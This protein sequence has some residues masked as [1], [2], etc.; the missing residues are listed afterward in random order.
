[1]KYTLRQLEVFKDLTETGS[2]SR[3]AERLHLTQPAVSIQLKRFQDQFDVPLYEIVGRRV[4]VTPF[5]R[6]L[7]LKATEILE[8]VD[9]LGQMSQS[10][11]G[12]LTGKL[13]FASVST[14][15][16]VLPYFIAP[17]FNEN[18][19]IDLSIDITNKAQVMES[20]RANTVDFALVSVLPTDMS[21]GRIGLLENRLELVGPSDGLYH[22]KEHDVGLLSTI[23]LIFREAGSG[24]RQTME[25]YFVQN[26]IIV[27]KT[28]E[29]T[30]NEAV[31]QAVLAGLG[32]SVMPLIG[33]RNEIN[34]GQI[35]VIRLKGF[36]VCTEWNII[37]RSEKRLSPAAESFLTY[38]SAKKQAVKDAQFSW[39]KKA[40]L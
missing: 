5:G 16:Y 12:V 18:P 33:L 20:L 38:L 15:K 1:M 14:G 13:S 36:P 29:L 9:A 40:E 7:A 37:W 6:L 21:V 11:K 32:Y 39:L 34:E 17:F 35:E 31:K 25:R 28:M 3:T 24:T 22:G 30:S 4:Q 8:G 10:H 27:R 26:N 23:P 19:G 2:V